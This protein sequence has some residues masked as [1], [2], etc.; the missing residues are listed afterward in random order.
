M[1]LGV[2]EQG[3]NNMNL[4]LKR[5]VRTSHSEEIAVFDS[6]T[7]DENDDA[8][9]IGKL[10][11]HYLGDQIVGTLLIWSEFAQGYNATHG[12]GSDE[13][14]DDLI[15]SILSEIAE[16]L[17]VPAEYGIE[18]YFPSVTNQ[19]FFSNYAHDG[20]VEGEEEY[21]SVAESEGEEYETGV[22]EHEGPGDQAGEPGRDD[23]Y[24]RRLARR[25]Q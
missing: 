17:G 2:R 7:R 3:G 12:P 5:V 10:E 1:T 13:T 16:P 24:Y 23:D 8:V 21:E 15:D 20:Q 22:G 9:S 25:E 11:V 14:M 6:D 19:S 18:V 4:K